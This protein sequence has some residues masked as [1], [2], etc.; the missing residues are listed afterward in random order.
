MVFPSRGLNYALPWI[1]SHANFS[2]PRSRQV[3]ARV[4]ARRNSWLRV[5]APGLCLGAR[6]RKSRIPVVLLSIYLHSVVA[7]GFKIYRKL[8]SH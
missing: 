5:E 8:R 4:S 7:F 3:R 6:E 1:Y 2:R